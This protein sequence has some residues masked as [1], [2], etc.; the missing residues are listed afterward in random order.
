MVKGSVKNVF[1]K[2]KSQV[3]ASLCSL[4]YALNEQL[5]S[6]K[7]SHSWFL[8]TRRQSLG[9]VAAEKHSFLSNYRFTIFLSKII[10]SILLHLQVANIGIIR[11]FEL[12]IC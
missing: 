12:R 9:T 4:Q 1:M 11:I 5:A 2:L 7:F 3:N 6:T 10:H 8:Q